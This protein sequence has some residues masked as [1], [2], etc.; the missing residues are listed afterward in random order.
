[1]HPFV[2]K[3]LF[4]VAGAAAIIIAKQ[5]IVIALDNLPISEEEVRKFSQKIRNASSEEIIKEA[6]KYLNVK[7]L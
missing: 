2:R 7:G 3:F 6:V 4:G 1:M 5:L